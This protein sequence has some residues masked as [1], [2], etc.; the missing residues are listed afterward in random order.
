[1]IRVDI[2]DRQSLF[3]IDRTIIRAWVKESL[4]IEGKTDA[5]ICIL[6]TDNAGIRELNKTYL[7]RDRSTNVISFSQQ[8][9]IGPVNPHLGDVV[10][11][12]EE[13]ALEAEDGGMPVSERILQLLVHGICHLCGYDHEGVSDDMVQQMETAE[14]MIRRRLKVPQAFVKR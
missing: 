3:A 9:G 1:M 14:E 10:I 13:A 7:G 6:F 4:R 8:E 2:L 5:E 12:L 11:S